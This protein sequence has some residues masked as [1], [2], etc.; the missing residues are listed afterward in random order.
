MTKTIVIYASIFDKAPWDPD[1]IHTGVSGSEEAV[2]YMSE[3]LAQ[4]GYQVLVLGNPPSDS[5]YSHANANPRYV[6]I[7]QSY[8]NEMVD[9]AIA[10]RHP[11]I[12]KELRTLGRKVYLWPHDALSIPGPEEEIDS[13]DDVLWL[14]EWQRQQHCYI[15]SSFAK[16]TQIFGNGINP[17]QFR[18][19]QEK[20]N[21]YSCIYSSSYERGLPI[22]LDL[23]PRIIEAQPRATLDIYYGRRI[24]E[25]VDPE[26]AAKI[27][28]Q[29][30]TLPNVREHGMVGHE[31]LARAYEAASFWTYP[32][33]APET[34][35]ITALKAQMGGAI[36]VIIESAALRET[37]RYGY[38]CVTPEE[39]FSTLMRAFEIVETITLQ[40][41][42]AMGEF[43]LKNYTWNHI[44]KRWQK[45]F[46]TSES[47]DIS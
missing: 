23:W 43:I 25:L 13:F 22:L 32:C 9:I 4:L 45:L 33:Q 37:V 14:T 47:K 16:F 6:H 31:E 28:M 46:E 19:L 8:F 20:A 41:R 3:Q 11:Y 38:R 17:E 12:G 27:R 36:P 21:P 29:I 26:K 40:D 1:S 42:K 44:A 15:Q 5:R 7:S 35:C 24:L 2:I 34:F 10:W 18:P 39:Y 30:E